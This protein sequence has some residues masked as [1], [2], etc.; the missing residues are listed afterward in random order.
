V[1]LLVLTVSGCSDAA[2][3]P[4]P[5][6]QVSLVDM[7]FV[8]DMIDH[9]KE[10][11]RS[12]SVLAADGSSDGARKLAKD[13]AT[14]ERAELATLEGLYE[15]WTGEEDESEAGGGPTYSP[16]P[17]DLTKGR[18]VKLLRRMIDLHFRALLAARHEHSVGVN[19]GARLTAERIEKSIRTELRALRQ[20]LREVRT[21]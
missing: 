3:E 9:H 16:R 12:A 1:L 14:E 15:G 18:E 6:A 8:K 2:P 20:L 5:P 17:V 19:P 4:Q 13:I 7:G 21:S 10:M 11:I